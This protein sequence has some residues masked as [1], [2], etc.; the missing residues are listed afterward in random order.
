M[1]NA[2]EGQPNAETRTRCREAEAQDGL[3]DPEKFYVDN[4]V[5]VR[6]EMA[7]GRL[8]SVEC[9]VEIEDPT[10]LLGLGSGDRFWVFE[11]PSGSLEGRV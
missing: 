9:E 4:G 3:V 11:G 2:D 10:G 1:S 7:V 5:D 6:L 8:D